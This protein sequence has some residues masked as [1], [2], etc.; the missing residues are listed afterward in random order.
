MDNAGV[1]NFVEIHAAPAKSS[2]STCSGRVGSARWRAR[3]IAAAAWCGAGWPKSGRSASMPRGL[4][5]DMTRDRHSRADAAHP[6]RDVPQYDRRPY[7]QR[8]PR[9]PISHG[10][11][12]AQG[13]RST[14][15]GSLCRGRA[16]SDANIIHLLLRFGAPS[17]VR[18]LKCVACVAFAVVFSARGRV[19]HLTGARVEPVGK[20]LFL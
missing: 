13:R 9:P 2:G 20:P 11:H 7:R 19:S 14:A 12:R 17:G 4:I 6:P 3:S 10:P 5:E 18:G 16:S 1:R 8:D 15:T